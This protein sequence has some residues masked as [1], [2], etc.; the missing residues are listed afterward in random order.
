[1]KSMI[2]VMLASQAMSLLAQKPISLRVN[3]VTV[4]AGCVA[5]MNLVTTE[6]TPLSRGTA[7]FEYDSSSD[8]LGVSTWSADGSAAGTAVFGNGRLVTNLTSATANLG[9]TA[10]YPIL[11]VAVRIKAGLPA[12]TVIPFNMN[13]STSSFQ[14]LFGPVAVEVQQG[15]I[16]VGGTMCV[17][18]VLPGGGRIAANQIVTV[19][20]QGFP[21][22]VRVDMEGVDNLAVQYISST[23]LR[24]TAPAPYVL[25]GKRVRVRSRAGEQV[26]YFA[27]M[28]GVRD[29]TSSSAL[30]NRTMPLVSTRSWQEAYVSPAVNTT[31]Q[32][33][34]IGLLNDSDTNATVTLIFQR[35]L[36][37]TVNTATATLTIAPRGLIVREAFELLKYKKKDGG[38]LRIVSTVPIRM[39]GMIA[40]D[41]AQTVNVAT[42]LPVR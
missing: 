29:G 7:G 15:T 37:S 2:A 11:S 16:T 5:Q 41:T 3:S 32:Y 27:Y 35:T 24:L 33:T 8:I 39:L 9:S 18:D 22:D 40:D 28:R 25:D 19:Q 17:T 20:G 1:M 10:E 38:T 13:L 23:E 14:N 34:G 6:P 42:T 36:S 30:L 31:T 12:G 4:P 26:I 21:T